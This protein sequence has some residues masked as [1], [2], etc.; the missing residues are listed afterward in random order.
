MLKKFLFLFKRKFIFKKIINSKYLV[1]EHGADEILLKYLKKKQ[2]QFVY[3]NYS[4]NF[5]I[6]LLL[7]LKFKNITQFNYY[8]LAVKTCDPDIVI[9]ATDDSKS[10]Y[11]LKHK[12]E[13]KKFLS[14]Q[15]G[16]RPS[17][18]IFDY[19]KKEKKLLKADMILCLGR[20][21]IKLYNSAINSK[22][23]PVGNIKNNFINK[24][25]NIKEIYRLV[26]I[27]EFR[28][29][30]MKTYNRNNYER[31]YD[32]DYNQFLNLF[33]SEKKIIKMLFEVSKQKKIPFY[34][35]GCSKKDELEEKKWYQKICDNKNINFI[36][37]KTFRTSYDFLLKSKYIANIDSTLGFEML[38]RN[39]RV[40]FFS[41][42]FVSK[43]MLN[44][45]K[46]GYPSV[47]Q[48]KG[49]FF[50]N[51]L[52]K[53]EIERL[54]NNM[55]KCKKEEW[56]NKIKNIKT[57]IVSYDPGNKKLIKVLKQLQINN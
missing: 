27:S 31:M 50:T 21:N 54:V 19:T 15:N 40:I 57:K 13:N 22:V 46:F 30:K 17:Y 49:F 48:D 12:F 43:K 51:E 10:F 7:I 3:F 20:H 25:K 29:D 32:C 9:T 28:I 55:I 14:I 16:Y 37:K 36:P 24:R 39:K 35:A 44:L 4:I 6:I 34:I 41:R 56:I 18:K 23:I 45:W 26:Y 53:K 52:N 1:L 42:S 38:S 5:Y 8:S 11:K 33:S 2:T 47:K